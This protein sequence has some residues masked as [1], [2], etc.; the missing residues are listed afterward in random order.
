MNSKNM[1]LT[2][3]IFLLG[4]LLTLLSFLFIIFKEKGIFEQRFTYHFQTLSAEFFQVGMPLKFSGFTVGAIDTIVLKDDASV[5]MTF[6]VIERHRK[7]VSEGSI[8]MVNKPLIGSPHIELFTSLG[9]PLLKDGS[10]L[11]IVSNDSIN[12]LISS[13]QPILKKALNILDS[14]NTITTY[15]AKEDSELKKTLINVEKLTYKLANDD[16]LLTSLTG[17]SSASKSMV[18]SLDTT[19]KVLEDIK[20]ITKDLSK[21]TSSLNTTVIEPTSASISE[22]ESIMKDIKQKLDALDGTVK[23]LGT[24]DKDLGELKTQISVGIQKSNQIIDKVD[25]FMSDDEDYKVV[26]P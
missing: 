24:Y 14:V 25:A 18:T 26:L 2:V 11:E 17:D 23:T 9:T 8:L 20:K 13:L 4:L 12:D 7:W 10:S 16:S 21:I 19:T 3:G 22:V 15:M 5:H 6:S 1:K